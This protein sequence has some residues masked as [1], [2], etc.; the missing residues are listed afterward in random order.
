ML[1]TGDGAITSAVG[2]VVAIRRVG[3]DEV[4]AF[5]GKLFEDVKRVAA[6]DVV[7]R[8]RGPHTIGRNKD[9]LWQSAFRQIQVFITYSIGGHIQGHKEGDFDPCWCQQIWAHASSL[10]SMMPNWSEHIF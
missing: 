3:Y 5:I 9:G 1:V 10:L 2:D 7:E 4:D 8:K 6:D